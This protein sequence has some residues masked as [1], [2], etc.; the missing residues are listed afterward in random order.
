MWYAVEIAFIGGKHYKSR[1]CFDMKSCHRRI[2][3]GECM[4]GMDEEPHNMT[5]TFMNGDIEIRTSWFQTKEQAIQFINGELTYVKHYMVWYDKGIRT[6]RQRFLKWETVKVSDKF[7]PF[8]GSCK[9]E[10][11]DGKEETMKALLTELCSA[12]D[13]ETVYRNFQSVGISKEQ[14]DEMLIRYKNKQ[15]GHNA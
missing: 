7:P 14:T 8:Q 15:F 12:Q 5:Q 10:Y 11:R 1:P 13:K 3:P 9:Y 4:A 6:M 2:G